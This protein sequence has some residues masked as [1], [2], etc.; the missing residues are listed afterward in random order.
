[1][2]SSRAR[3]TTAT[4]ISDG[5]VLIAGGY[6]EGIPEATTQIVLRNDELYDPQTGTFSLVGSSDQ[7]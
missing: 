3:H 1:M 4:L 6:S 5:K 2:H 7:H